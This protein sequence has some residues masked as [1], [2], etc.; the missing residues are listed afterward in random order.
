MEFHFI[1]AKLNLKDDSQP[2]L[3]KAR[4]IAY[5]L[6]PKVEEELRRLQNEG[7]LTE[8]KWSDWVTPI[9][10]VTKKDG[11]I[12]LCGDY[13]VTVSPELKA[14]KYPLPRTEDI[15]ANLAGGQKFSN[16]DLCQAYHQ[17]EMEENSKKYRTINT[18]MGLFQY[19]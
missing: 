2:R 6:K 10:P 18:H 14:E 4:P 17:L 1:E 7:I 13:K 16:V 19:N 12:R 8:R 3:L 11:S 5:A 15:F 9:V